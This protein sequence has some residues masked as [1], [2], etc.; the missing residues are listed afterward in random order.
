MKR[1]GFTL[2]ELI[3][4]LVI[5]SMLSLL[6]AP[7]IIS[8]MQ[9]SKSKSFVSEAE[10]LVSTATYMYKTESNRS[11][12]IFVGNDINGY[13]IY[14]KSL[15]GNVPT[16]DPYGYKYD[17]ESSYIFFKEPAAN[18]TLG[19]RTVNVHLKSCKDNKCHCIDTEDGT[20]ITTK[21]IKDNC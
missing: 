11:K 13:K 8:L 16:E 20:N 18:E 15:N 2:V 5:L 21:D 17:L 4:V 7:N 9:S 14:M 6:A 3:A 10:E 19:T 12:N 1:N